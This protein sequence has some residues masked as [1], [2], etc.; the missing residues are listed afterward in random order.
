MRS[1]DP[2]RP[3]RAPPGP[4]DSL[5][6]NLVHAARS[7]T[8]VAE[9]WADSEGPLHSTPRATSSDAAVGRWSKVFADCRV[10][11]LAPSAAPCCATAPTRGRCGG[12]ERL[13]G[14]AASPR[15]RPAQ[16]AG[17]RY[18][19]TAARWLLGRCV[20]VRRG[21]H[22]RWCG[23]RSAGGGLGRSPKFRHVPLRCL[24]NC[25]AAVLH[26]IPPVRD[27]DSIGRPA[28][29]AVGVA[30]TL[31]LGDQLDA[32]AGAQPGCDAVRLAVG[33]QVNDGIEFQVDE[34]RAV[35]LPSLP[36]PASTPSRRGAV[37]SVT[38]APRRTRRIRVAPLTDAPTRSARRA[39]TLPPD[40]RLMRCCRLPRCAVRR[41]I[42]AG[43]STVCEHELQ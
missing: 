14:V 29:T 38:G 9:A 28:P 8:Q 41:L 12:S 43:T 11:H 13:A 10:R 33:W 5:C 18:I 39:P 4:G 31:I 27:M 20:R 7:A 40:A 1:R 25:R 2:G 36:R 34:D 24:K 22:G 32:G 15:H 17:I 19:A 6:Q 26:Q 21:R 37:A 16:A 30:C 42:R 3:V 23:D 35:A